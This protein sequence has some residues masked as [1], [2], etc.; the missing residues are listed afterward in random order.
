[1][2]TIEAFDVFVDVFACK[3]P[4]VETPDMVNNALPILEFACNTSVVV[5]P[6]VKT[7]GII[8]EVFA[9]KSFTYIVF[10]TLA[11]E[12][13]VDESACNTRMNPVPSTVIVGVIISVFASK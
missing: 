7:V 8:A 1:M 11:L 5:V 3:L 9:T 10:V 13:F 2:F 12:V 4:V 6:D